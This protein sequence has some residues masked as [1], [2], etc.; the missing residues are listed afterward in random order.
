MPG[1]VKPFPDTNPMISVKTIRTVT[2]ATLHDELHHKSIY[3]LGAA[4]VLFVFLLR[5]CFNNDVV[6]NGQKLDGATIGWHASLIAFHLIASAGVLVGILLGMRVLRR[7]RTD[8]TAVAI[9][10]RPVRRIEYLLGKCLGVWIIAYGLTFILH[11]TVYGIMLLKT[12]GR[13]GFFLPASLLISMNVLFAVVSVVLLAQFLPDIAAALA[14]S[15][16]WLVG[17][18]SDA[19]YMASQTGMVKNVL[20]QMQ[21]PET[22]IALWRVIWPKMTALQY[23]G[24]ARIKDVPFHVPGPVHPAVNVSFYVVVVFVLL[25]LHFSREEIR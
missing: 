2:G 19:I 10:S 11:L 14:A 9:L 4:A 5:G 18:I 15:G 20:E 13:I 6:M 7:D 8:G 16:I 1:V 21:R 24:V 12:G 3:F 17:Y 23:Y 22:S 25:Y